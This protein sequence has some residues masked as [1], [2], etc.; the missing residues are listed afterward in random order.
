M[1]VKQD[2]IGCA[3]GLCRALRQAGKQAWV[4][5]N[6]DIT[7]LFSPYLEG[8]LL[9]EGEQP[10][11]VV[12]VDL[13]SRNLFSPGGRVWLDRGID[14][15]ID[16]HPSY[17]GFAKTCWVDPGRAACGELILDLV[18]EL[19]PLTQE[20]AVPL[21]VA[22]S[23]DT[24]CFVYGNT[25]PATHRAAAALMETGIDTAALNKRHFRTK[26]WKRVQIE[27]TLMREL[28]RHD[29]GKTALAVISLALMDQLSAT[30]AD[31]EDVASLVGQVEGVETSVTIREQQDGS[32]KL[33]VRTSGGLDAN[34]VCG[35]LGGGGH[36]AASGCVITGSIETAKKSILEAIH[37][38][39]TGG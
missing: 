34:K 24:G 32:C 7:P 1:D 17:E 19:G 25:T 12:S 36:A 18:S 6:E 33:S 21:Y 38:V 27:S 31:L 4:L 13:S 35:L 22:I 10:E 39:Q 9:P 26:S 23:T 20:I 28:E 2:T 29:G 30:S 11:F 16:H 15:A 37:T 3:A 14:L 5:P 8:L